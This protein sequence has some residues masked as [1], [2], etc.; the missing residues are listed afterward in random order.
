MIPHQFWAME[1]LGYEHLFFSG[2]SVISR[3]MYPL[4]PGIERG[5]G[6][7]S[8]RMVYRYVFFVF[9]IRPRQPLV[10]FALVL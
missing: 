7:L 4:Y 10:E 6:V 8:I 3:L 9:T 2:F 1:I 5:T